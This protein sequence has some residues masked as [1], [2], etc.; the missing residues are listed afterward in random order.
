MRAIRLVSHTR[1]FASFIAVLRIWLTRR[2]GE[3]DWD[4]Q[5]RQNSNA[6]R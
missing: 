3:I 1:R 6:V 2:V 5:T 4:I